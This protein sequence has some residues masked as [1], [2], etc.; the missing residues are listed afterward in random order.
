[1]P[2]YFDRCKETTTS[3]GAGDI[4][5]AGA[6]TGFRT[7]NAAYG[8]DAWIPYCI[9]AVDGSGVPTGDWEVGIGYLS[10][11]TNFKRFIVTASSTGSIL[12]LAAGTKNLF[13][14]LP[15]AR[16]GRSGGQMMAYTLIGG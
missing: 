2:V 14:T 9:E 7:L 6:V 1:M 5:T 8:L 10:T 16:V 4:T 3:T 15:A 12:T 13:A 11:T